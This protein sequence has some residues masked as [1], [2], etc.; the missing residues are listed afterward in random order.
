M[1]NEPAEPRATVASG[2]SRWFIEVPES[3]GV[4]LLS[5]VCR[6]WDRSV[7]PPRCVYEGSLSDCEERQAELEEGEAPS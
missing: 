2:A 1:P 4:C 3:S 5:V 6:L 7:T